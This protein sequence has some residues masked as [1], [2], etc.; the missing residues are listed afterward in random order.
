MKL[1][2]TSAFLVLAVASGGCI[3]LG[4]GTDSEPVDINA[5]APLATGFRPG[6]VMHDVCIGV[7]TDHGFVIPVDAVDPG[8]GVVEPGDG[9][10]VQPEPIDGLDCPPAS[11]GNLGWAR[12]VWGSGSGRAEVVL[13]YSTNRGGSAAATDADEDAE[14]PADAAP[15]PF[16]EAPPEEEPWEED[17]PEEWPDEPTEDE[18]VSERSARTAATS[19]ARGLIFEGTAFAGY[20]VTVKEVIAGSPHTTF[21]LQIDYAAADGLDAA[22]ASGLALVGA[23][24]ESLRFVPDDPEFIGTVTSGV[25]DPIVADREGRIFM[26]IATDSLDC[27]TA[28][29]FTLYLQPDGGGISVLSIPCQ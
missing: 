7:D 10:T 5:G 18:E 12:L 19:P 17:W 9:A 8:G 11:D 14:E 22:T 2:T 26:L 21:I 25:D 4:G 1:T 3:V 24:A 13:E 28:D 6:M 29:E 16:E 27:A 23:G 15:D 20:D